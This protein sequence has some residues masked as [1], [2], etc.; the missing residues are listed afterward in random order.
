MLD[1]WHV[2]CAAGYVK[3]A[4]AYLYG[5]IKKAVAG[6]FRLWAA[7]KSDTAQP[8]HSGPVAMPPKSPPQASPAH[9]E[10]S[11]ARQT[12]APAARQAGQAYLEHLRGL[13]DRPKSIRQVIGELERH[14]VLSRHPEENWKMD[15]GP[16][17]AV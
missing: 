2:R 14:G 7:R 11:T 1:E 3:N 13:L 10:P 12:L 6:Q 8:I 4:V 17:G 16:P 5:L 9:A 15:Y